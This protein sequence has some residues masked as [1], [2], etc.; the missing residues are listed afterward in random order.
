MATPPDSSSGSTD[1][2]VARDRFRAS[3]L[4]KKAANA[5]RAAPAVGDVSANPV[6]RAAGRVAVELVNTLGGH[7]ALYLGLA[8]QTA[9][10]TLTARDPFVIRPAADRVV[11]RFRPGALLATP[12]VSAAGWGT[13]AETTSSGLV[14]TLTRTTT[15]WSGTSLELEL[16]G[17]RPDA[18]VGA[19]A[20]RVEVEWQLGVPLPPVS[21]TVYRRVALSTAEHIAVPRPVL[22][23]WWRAEAVAT[24]PLTG[25][26]WNTLF[27]AADGTHLCLVRISG[28]TVELGAYFQSAT[29]QF[30]AAATLDST[31][32]ARRIAVEARG[33]TWDY[34]VDG[35]KVGT[36]QVP[37]VVVLPTAVEW[38][39]GYNSGQSFGA[40]TDVSVQNLE[41]VAGSLRGA[42][43]LHLAVMQGSDEIVRAFDARLDSHQTAIQDRVEARVSVAEGA[44]RAHVE[45]TVLTADTAL[46]THVAQA[47]AASGEAFSDRHDEVATRLAEVS[48][49]AAGE[50]VRA[51]IVGSAAVAPSTVGDAAFANTLALRVVNVSG[52]SLSEVSLSVDLGSGLDELAPSAGWTAAWARGGTPLGTGAVLTLASWPDREALDLT[53]GNVCLPASA[54]LGPKKLRVAYY[55]QPGPA[56]TVRLGARLPT[57]SDSLVLE[58]A[59]PLADH[60]EWTL[61]LSVKVQQGGPSRWV[62]VAV[63]AAGNVLDFC[64]P[65]AGRVTFRGPSGGAFDAVDFQADRYVRVAIR[66]S[67]GKLDM[68]ADGRPI[69]TRD[70]GTT[71]VAPG[72]WSQVG[73]G[74]VRDVRIWSRGLSDHEIASHAAGHRPVGHEPGLLADVPLDDL[75][76]TPRNRAW[77]GAS[78]RADPRLLVTPAN[79]PSGAAVPAQPVSGV[80]ALEV[81]VSNIVQARTGVTLVRGAAEVVAAGSRPG[82]LTSPTV[83]AAADLTVGVPGGAGAL[84]VL[85]PAT[86]TGPVATRPNTDAVGFRSAGMGDGRYLTLSTVPALGDAWTAE[87]T[88]EWPLPETTDW[89]TLFRGANEHHLLVRRSDRALGAFLLRPAGRVN[90]WTM[91][92]ERVGSFEPSGYAFPAD[93]PPGWHRLTL[94]ARGRTLTYYVD[95]VQVGQ[96][97]RPATSTQED[98][99]TIGDLPAGGQSIGRVR[100]VRIWQS[101]PDGT[102]VTPS[103]APA[104][105]VVEG[106]PLPTGVQYA[107]QPALVGVA[108]RLTPEGTIIMWSGA[109]ANIPTGWH[110]CDGRSLT[111]G[112]Q[113]VSAPNLVGRMIRGAASAGGTGGADSI[114]LTVAQ[115]PSHRH[116][117]LDVYFSESAEDLPPDSVKVKVPMGQGSHGGQDWDNHGDA[118]HATTDATGESGAISILPA[119]YELAFLI[120][121]PGYV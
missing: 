80:V 47:V 65:S 59:P 57:G 18:V 64:T 22:G 94:V 111:K 77:N 39:G 87:A 4:A 110:L 75:D 102:G 13:A 21:R 108:A 101:A 34:F 24:F 44:L 109:V 89:N 118:M 52:S 113:T 43:S 26:G 69:G 23:A 41:E 72:G 115:L 66:C 28:T 78:R 70:A 121:Y 53:L 36:V 117:Y 16:E 119:Y 71:D 79:A 45:Q 10:L 15:Q 31:D 30:H 67:G 46:R 33:R 51:W 12:T 1:V 5:G 106:S 9:R 114:V 27:R 3:W 92:P 42:R 98:I 61:E 112:S 63:R 83:K 58:F 38:V 54:A 14:L 60:G 19:H 100:R 2:N 6:G 90:V 85:G 49:R 32:G 29:P 40:L 62:G 25:T 20:V 103:S 8:G 93:F 74:R 82:T 56:D 88:C 37:S 91:Q 35:A 76:N 7:P 99:C 107:G 48:L 68:F 97:Q 116:T 96:L 55:G 73:R 104:L 81:E 11:L 95:G 120:F 17:M 84:T 50:S 86:V 105:E